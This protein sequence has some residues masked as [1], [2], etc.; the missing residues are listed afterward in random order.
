MPVLHWI[1]GV[2]L[3]VRKLLC[4]FCLMSVCKVGN[5]FGTVGY[6][7]NSFWFVGGFNDTM[8]STLDLFGDNPARDRTCPI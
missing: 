8:D 5:K 3:V 1:L 4:E 2:I 6:E 7:R